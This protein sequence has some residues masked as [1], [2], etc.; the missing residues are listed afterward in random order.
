MREFRAGLS[1][2]EVDTFYPW[3]VTFWSRLA[4]NNGG[5]WYHMGYRNMSF[6]TER[7]ARRAIK[8]NLKKLRKQEAAWPHD[9]KETIK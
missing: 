8:H 6:A 7:S 4:S 2:N 1:R 5:D 9:K 3:D